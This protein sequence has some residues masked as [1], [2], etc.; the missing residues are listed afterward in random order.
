M[1]HSPASRAPVEEELSLPLFFATVVASLATFYGLFW[2]AAPTVV[3]NRELSAG[4][5]CF[6]AAFLLIKLFNCFVEYFFHRY[7]LHK[8]VIP[9][10]SR[11]YKQH[12]LH[13]TLTRIT[14][15]QTPG[16]RE[17]PYVENIFP[18]TEPEQKE[19]SFFPWYTLAVFGVLVT[20]L[21]ALLHWLLP[22]FP[23]FLAGYA[24]LATSLI[25]Y[26][27]FHAIEHW[28]FETWARL[29]E[30]PRWGRFWRKVYSFHLR[31]HA[32]IDCNEAIS[33]FFTLPVADFVFGTWVF[34]KTL[35]TDGGEWEA[36]EFAS[37]RPC[38]FVRWCDESADEL[39]RQRRLQA[40]GVKASP[41]P[42]GDTWPAASVARP[43]ASRWERFAHGLTHGVGLVM[44]TT[45]LVLLVVFAALK[46]D[47]WHLASFTVFGVTLVLLYTAFAIY[48]RDTAAQWRQTLRKYN[49]AA[50]FLVIAGTATPFL[51]VS[52]RG[53]WG[54]SLF[55]VAWGLCTAGVA[56]Q[57]LFSGRY[58]AITA[59]FYLLVGVLAVVAIK[60]VFAY[61][62]TGALS[63]GLAGALSY[64]VGVAFYFWKLPRYELLP[65]HLFLFGGSVCHTLALLLFVL[66]ASH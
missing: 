23:W 64:A 56:F 50:I 8:P 27:V 52:M 61:L 65:R 42:A 48:Y 6:V 45:S 44:S 2:L 33:G 4:A 66:P 40:Q 31:H 13:H 51:L 21:F 62:P 47:T 38:R 41:S 34:P 26:E 22:A 54:W 12:T 1:S 49:H 58:R 3:R 17:I 14:R 39:I 32:V 59:V 10:L 36:S 16:G 37:P 5:G 7:V 43:A 19:A 11:F 35:Y 46:G 24:A 53:A 30:N 25:F 18:I 60:P 20:P 9:F 55:G 57:W 63:L 28:P 15:R 29:I